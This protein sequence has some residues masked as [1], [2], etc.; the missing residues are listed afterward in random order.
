MAEN[1]CEL[2]GKQ[3]ALYICRR[4]GNRIC[5]ACFDYTGWV[6]SIC[7]KSATKPQTSGLKKLLNPYSFPLIF[8][9]GS[10]ITFIGVVIIFIS[11]L[12]SPSSIAGGGILLIGPIPIVFGTGPDFLVLLPIAVALTIIAFVFFFLLLTP[13]L[14]AV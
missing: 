11:A 7:A 12:G 14:R 2:C 6:C 13:R 10:L 1:L 3:D 4:C 5:E 9:V 8:M